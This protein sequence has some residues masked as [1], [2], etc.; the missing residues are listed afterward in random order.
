MVLLLACGGNEKPHKDLQQAF[1]LHEE[2]M[3]IR[4][5]TGDELAKLTT[6]EDSLF[7]ATYKTDFE[8]IASSLKEWDDQLVEVPGF[9]HADGHDHSGHDHS[10]H[11]HSGHDHGHGEQQELTPE[12]HLE[13]QQHLL[14]EIKAMA[15]KVDQ[16]KA[17][18]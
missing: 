1:E 18:Q 13:V 14:Q 4:N 2:A 10:G 5:Q 16:I 9:E 6:I 7:V 17:K 11:D 15:E 8:S 3:K 12:Q